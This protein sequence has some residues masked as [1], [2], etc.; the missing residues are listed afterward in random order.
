MC[1]RCSHA[2][3]DHESNGVCLTCARVGGSCLEPGRHP[4][5][6]TVTLWTCP[7]GSLVAVEMP[8]ATTVGYAAKRMADAIGLDPDGGEYFLAYPRTRR[9]LNPDE[10]VAPLNGQMVL[11]GVRQG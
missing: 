4:I 10:I 11:I 6:T 2:L 8:G 3:D 5:E 1:G 9:V 7:G